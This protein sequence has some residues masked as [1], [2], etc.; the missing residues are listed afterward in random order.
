MRSQAG[1]MAGG[2]VVLEGA[3]AARGPG[4]SGAG[5]L[6]IGYLIDS[7]TTGGAERLVVTFAE[8]VKDRPD[9]DL[10]VFVL[11]GKA[12]PFHEQLVGLG[13]RVVMLPGSGIGDLPRFARLVRALR[14]ARLDC[15]HAH[16]TSATVLG[17][18][19]AALLRIPF[20]VTIHNVRPSTRRVTP[21]R[22]LVY[23]MAL[24][25]P[26]IRRI[27]VGR[28]VA[29]ALET[30]FGTRDAIVVPNAIAPSAVAPP[31][32]RAARRAELG[33]GD[34]EWGL[35]AVGSLI[36]QK[37]YLD[38]F[39]AFRRVSASEPKAVLLI[40]GSSEIEHA[41]LLRREAEALGLGDRLRFLGLHRDVPGL[42]AASDLFVSASHWEGAPV[43]LLEAMA[44]GLPCCVTDVGENALM[45]EGVDA[46]LSPPHAP[47]R[48][49]ESVLALL[50][51]PDRRAR[52]AVQ[53]REKAMGCYGASAWADRLVALYADAA[54][55]GP[56]GLRA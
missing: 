19:A 30:E 26:G 11:N 4:A 40:A 22:R 9:V 42:L 23:R 3:D 20:A 1:T 2:R 29:E 14:R 31:Q 35:A 48:L 5:P 52:A 33:L 55:P 49:A 36:P 37:G 16:L 38:L 18:F 12:T 51:D 6:R 24:S 8:A 47:E 10:T 17:S 39:A 32:V 21:Q 56:A 25:R 28:A 53:G 7:L 43:A 45:L 15:L 44:N 41:R 34:D 54:R 50:D 46:G 27:A 13:T